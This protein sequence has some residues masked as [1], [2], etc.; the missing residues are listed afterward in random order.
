MNNEKIIV[1]TD[2]D[3]TLLDHSTYSYSEAEDALRLLKEKRVPL[4]L[5]SSKSRVEIEVYRERLSNNEPFISENGGAI[6]IPELYKGLKCEFDKID[7]GYLVIEIGSEYKTLIDA[8]EQLKRNTGANIKSITE[9]TVDEIVELTGL[10]KEEASLAQKRKYT[11]PFIVNGGEE[12]VKNIK[13][14]ILSLGLNYTE[15]ARFVHLMGGNDKGKAVKVLVDIFKKNYPETRI[16]TIGLGDSLNDLPMLEA[17]DRAFLVKKES[18]NYEERIK[19]E[20]LIYADGI[21]PVGWNK[22]VLGLFS[23]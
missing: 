10:N 6:F 13:N 16:I 8:F 5:C 9:F 14:E 12:H 4:I 1:F 17:V 11:L 22:A 3:G 7:N 21:G 18:G 20:G 23:R 2:L 19:T 15:G